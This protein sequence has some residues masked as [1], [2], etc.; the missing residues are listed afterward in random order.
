[1]NI[2]AEAVEWIRRWNDELSRPVS[3]RFIPSHS[4]RGLALEAFIETFAGFAPKVR[5]SPEESSEGELP[6]ILLGNSV[7]WQTIPEGGELMPFL[8]AVAMNFSPG[9]ATAFVPEA[10]RTQIEN[11]SLPADLK[12]YVLPQCPFCPLVLGEIVPLALLNPLL[13]LAVID[14][15]FFP[16]LAEGDNIRSV[17]TV[18]LDGA[19]R[20]VGAG[21]R[22]EILSAILNRDPACL[23]VKSLTDFLKEGNAGTLAQMMIDRR[24]VF[25]AFTDLLVNSDWTVRLGAMVVVEE[26]AERSQ[27]LLE[28]MLGLLWNQLHGISGSARGDVLYL[29]GL[30]QPAKLWAD[31]MKGLIES[32]D[33]EG[34]EAVT[35]ALEKL[36][37]ASESA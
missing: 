18:I 19:F 28:E 25:P 21:H 36:E 34:R 32:E 5:F 23:D 22:D 27:V 11:V 1:M 31:R 14:V 33:E 16:E 8:N 20:W 30:G 9:R 6:A 17:P 4:K 26:I 24:Q 37:G 7:R 10:L 2:E 12:I 3:V 35:D 29:F 13:H 15:A